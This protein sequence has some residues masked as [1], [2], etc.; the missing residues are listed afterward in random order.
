MLQN[1]IELNRAR[2]KSYKQAKKKNQGFRVQPEAATTVLP[3]TYKATAWG[4]LD[5]LTTAELFLSLQKSL[6]GPG[7]RF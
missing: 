2:L 1:Q 6:E 3:L 7:T 4:L 5:L